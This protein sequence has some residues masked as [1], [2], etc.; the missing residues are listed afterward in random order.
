MRMKINSNFAINALAVYA[1]VI[2]I[3]LLPFFFVIARVKSHA[4]ALVIANNILKTITGRYIWDLWGN[5]TPEQKKWAG[6]L[7][8]LYRIKKL[9]K[10]K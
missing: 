5:S 3:L 9:I 10:I 4:A 1:Y 2:L 7:K 6:A 8:R